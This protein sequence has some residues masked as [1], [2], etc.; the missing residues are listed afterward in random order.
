MCVF[1]GCCVCEK[2]FC[3]YQF[4]PDLSSTWILFLL[5]VLLDLQGWV[6]WVAG[7]GLVWFGLT[8]GVW[9][10][11]IWVAVSVGLWWFEF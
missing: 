3:G 4:K 9:I 2:K 7:I 10:G 5:G 11:L 8:V 1:F 6:V